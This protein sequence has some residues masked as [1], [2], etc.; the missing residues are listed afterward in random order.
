MEPLWRTALALTGDPAQAHRLTAQALAR[1]GDSRDAYFTLYR[2]FLSPFRRWRRPVVAGR[3]SRREWAAAVGLRHDEWSAENVADLLGWRVAKVGRLAADASA[4]SA[5]VVEETPQGLETGPIRELVESYRKRRFAAACAGVVGTVTALF[6]AALLLSPE[7]PRRAE[8]PPPSEPYVRP[9]LARDLPTGPGV[10]VRYA[11][12]LVDRYNETGYQ[13]SWA[14]VTA[15]GERRVLAGLRGDLLKVSHD[16]RKIAHHDSEKSELTLMDVTSGW[17]KRLPLQADRFGGLTLDFSLDGRYVAFQADE[18]PI[19][20]MDLR[21]PE[22]LVTYPDE[23]ITSWTSRGLM[24]MDD[25]RENGWLRRPDGSKKRIDTYLADPVLVS[26]DGSM[27]AHADD[28]EPEV[29]LGSLDGDG[30]DRTITLKDDNVLGVERWVG[31]SA[32]IVSMHHGGYRLIDV[33][34]GKVRPIEIDEGG[35]PEVVFGK[36]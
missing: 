6:L 25:D 30:M 10:A 32:V 2:R 26:S 18:D 11:Y 36:L 9:T 15:S 21:H 13:D 12:R 22:K 3:R 27:Y 5:S 14:V 16:G 33:R 20:V 1:H 29:Y 34:T 31:S 23:M 17:T 7:A 24:T 19:A 35:Y 4:A 28:R 8:Y